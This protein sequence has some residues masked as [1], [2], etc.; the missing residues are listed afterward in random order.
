MNHVRIINKSEQAIILRALQ[1]L[2][3]DCSSKKNNCEC[4][5]EGDA[6]NYL[7]NQAKKIYEKL[8]NKDINDVRIEDVRSM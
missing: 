7:L 3:E 5:D 2:M 6:Y 8:D 1:T 4:T